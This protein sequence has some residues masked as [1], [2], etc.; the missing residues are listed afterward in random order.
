M[1][2][3]SPLVPLVMFGWLP[4][5]VIAFTLMPPRR[6]VIGSFVLGWLLLPNYSYVFPGI[7]NYTKESAS[8]LGVLLGVAIFDPTRIF[9]F[10]LR[11]V[12]LPMVLWCLAPI[13][14]SL[15]VGTGLYDGL[16]ATFAQVVVWGL[17]YFV[18]RMY[19]SDLRTLKE[20]AVGVVLGGLLYVPL[21]LYEIR[22]SPQL[23][24][25]FYGFHQH[26]FAQTFRG[27][28]W[29]PV[30]FLEHGL[31][32][33]MWMSTSAL[34]AYGL[35]RFRTVT[36][37]G[38]VAM[39]T[40]VLVLTFTMVLV[41][42][43]GALLL[44]VV[45]ILLIEL[46]R[47]RRAGWP[48]LHVLVVLPIAYL[49]SQL[50]GL[51]DPSSVAEMFRS[52]SEDRYGSLQFRFDQERLLLAKAWERPLF[53]WTPWTFQSVQ[54]QSGE[55]IQVVTDSLWIIVFATRGL[56]GLITVY[57]V[58]LLPVVLGSRRILIRQLRDP[59]VAPAVVLG[60]VL[61]LYAV[62]HLVNAMINPI[63]MLLAGG[64]GTL[65]VSRSTLATDHSDQRVSDPRMTP[66]PRTL[67][68]LST[69]LTSAP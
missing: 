27:G 5:V 7:P 54:D 35:W 24:T 44:L 64:L 16:S 8:L 19:F 3:P 20:L 34:I 57:A 68:E 63:Y 60:L 31:M 46:V 59:R 45:G 39:G 25:I 56:F 18:G 22:F 28:G 50:L 32:V 2:H 21:C 9:Q 30:V 62:D 40:I 15:T 37:L 11:M 52:Y 17:P 66:A 13:P 12:D 33:G 51:W 69:G 10:R 36:R 61:G 67:K 1:H 23:H 53:G 29:R 43:L 48:L 4:L 41:K 26:S 14:S 55:V 38:P 49:M 58:M 6:A 65:V 47:S 42:S